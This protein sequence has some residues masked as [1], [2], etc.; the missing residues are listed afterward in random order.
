MK[1]LI[2]L[3][4]VSGLFLAACQEESKPAEPE[5]EKAETVE[6]A[7]AEEKQTDEETKEEEAPAEE[8]ADTDR[9]ITLNE[10]FKLKNSTITI[11][12]F[13]LAKGFEG[14][15]VLKVT[16]NWTNDADEATAPLFSVLFKGFQDNVQVTS[17]DF[18][19]G[20]NYE[21]GQ[22]EVKPG[23]SIEG[24]EEFMGIDDLSKPYILE[25]EEAFSFSNEDPFTITLDLNNLP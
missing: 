14:G 21:Q 15:D 19:E 8:T 23:G 24:A 4:A 7:P 25:V 16:Y 13:E 12:G 18:V 6:E 17:A 2:S 22:K 3:L 9:E 10:P 11:T 1:K 5:A 20:G